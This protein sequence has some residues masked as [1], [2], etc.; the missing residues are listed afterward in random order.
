M[1]Q[2]ETRSWVGW[3]HHMT[4]VGLAHLFVTLVRRRLKKKLLS[5]R[6]LVRDK[7]RIAQDGGFSRVIPCWESDFLA[8]IDEK[9]RTMDPHS[10]SME[11][12][13]ARHRRTSDYHHV[14]PRQPS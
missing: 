2:Y 10:C 13:R 9:A 1:T 3:H 12:H 5:A 8:L 6:Q 11:T 14:Q 4:L 7:R